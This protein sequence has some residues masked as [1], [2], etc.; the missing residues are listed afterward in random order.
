MVVPR[1]SLRPLQVA[2]IHSPEEKERRKIF[3]ACIAKKLGTSVSPPSAEAFDELRA[4]WEEWGDDDEDPRE[5]PDIEDIVD[6]SG[7]L[8]D[9]QPAYDR[10]INAEVQLQLGDDFQK[11]KVVGRAIGPDGVV[12][13]QYDENPMLNSIVYEVEF[14]DGT[15]REYSA[16]L[17]AE[18]MLTQVDSDGYSLTLMEG[19]VDYRRSE[20]GA[21]NKDD[22]YVITRRGKKQ[23]RKTTKGWLLLIRWKDQTES[24]VPLKD[25]KESHPVEVAEFV[26]ARGIH[27]EPAFAWW[28]PYTL[29][30]RDV[31]IAAIKSRI[32]KTTHKYGIEVP[33]SV[34]HAYDIDLANGNTFWRDAIKLGM[35]NVGI[36]F[37]STG[38]RSNCTKVAQSDAPF[39]FQREDELHPE[40]LVGP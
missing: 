4:T 37:E 18:N 35:T 3:D 1:R 30:K 2:E 7:R 27:E 39:C 17:I 23:L 11:A 6:G 14:D 40:C 12:V 24:W 38:G 36:V 28:V 25:M 29:R 15:I 22:G 16:N 26:K 21:V 10:M 19:I 13:G 8:L 20:T 33:T 31:I 9:Q 32:R 5:V 34:Q